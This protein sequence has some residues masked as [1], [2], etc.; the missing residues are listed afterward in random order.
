MTQIAAASGIKV[1]QIYRDF[2]GKEAIVAEL[3]RADLAD[4]LDEAELD[5]A[6]ARGDSVSVRR[7]LAGFL[8]E[9]CD[10]NGGRLLAHIIVEAARNER[11]AALFRHADRL[12]NACLARAIAALAPNAPD[13]GRRR[14]VDMM[15]TVLMGLPHRRLAQPDIDLPRVAADFDA[16]VEREIGRLNEGQNV[17][18]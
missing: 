17:T 10:P 7:W 6:I 12:I 3:V 2:D 1:G 18:P 15:M 11:I 16:L 4:F 8:Q 13:D 14:L 5:A 9:D